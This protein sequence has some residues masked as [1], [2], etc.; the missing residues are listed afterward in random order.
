MTLE[1]F[2]KRDSARKA[3]HRFLADLCT[4]LDNNDHG[5]DIN[6]QDQLQILNAA[7]AGYVSPLGESVSES[8]AD[9]KDVEQGEISEEAEIF[10]INCA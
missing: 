4:K 9:L 6:L 5:E 7:L 8:K 1:Y 2:K 3:V 10:V